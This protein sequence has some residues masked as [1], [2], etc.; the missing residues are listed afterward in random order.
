M[1]LWSILPCTSVFPHILRCPL[2][3]VWYVVIWKGSDNSVLSKAL[4]SKCPHFNN[5]GKTDRPTKLCWLAL[6][7]IP[8]RSAGQT[9]IAR[10][11]DNVT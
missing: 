11:L 3:S 9:T 5:K 6:P 7:N 10:E 8:L 4:P 1:L 2:S